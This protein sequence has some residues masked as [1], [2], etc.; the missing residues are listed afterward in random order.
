[1]VPIHSPSNR[2]NVVVIFL[3]CRP[4]GLFSVFQLWRDNIVLFTGLFVQL[5][6]IPRSLVIALKPVTASAEFVDCLV[7]EKLLQCPL[8]NVLTLV[9]LKLSDILDGA[10]EDGAFVLFAARNNLLEFIDAFIDSLATAA[11]NWVKILA[12]VYEGISMIQTYLL[13]GCLA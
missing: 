8:L 4:S 7:K 11:L 3:L 13:Y 6:L 10:L 1:M 2:S 12:L 5:F 9:I